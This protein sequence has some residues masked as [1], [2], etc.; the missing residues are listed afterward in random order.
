MTW[1]NKEAE[2]VKFQS[3]GEEI[4]EPENVRT[5]DHEIH[6][7]H[8]KKSQII[9]LKSGDITLSGHKG[10]ADFLENSVAELLLSPALQM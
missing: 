7:N 2:K 6:K 10:C 4:N 1:H 9:K 5:Y 3:R 8:R